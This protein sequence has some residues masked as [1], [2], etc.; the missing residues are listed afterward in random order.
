MTFW[1][2]TYRKT[3]YALYLG[4]WCSKLL[5]YLNVPTVNRY[6]YEKKVLVDHQSAH[7]YIKCTRI[8]PKFL[9]HLININ[10]YYYNIILYLISTSTIVYPPLVINIE[11]H[12][13]TYLILRY[14]LLYLLTML[15]FANK[16]Y[17]LGKEKKNYLEKSIKV[18]THDELELLFM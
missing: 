14:T 17:Y 11:F 9:L 10:N 3:S 13:R 12:I 1:T 16:L 18:L 4:F 8:G 7:T 15:H 2:S 5:T 6:V